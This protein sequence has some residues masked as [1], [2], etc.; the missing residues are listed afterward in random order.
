MTL[1]RTLLFVFF[2]GN[3]IAHAQTTRYEAELA[4]LANGATKVTD[5]SRSGGAYVQTQEGDITFNISIPSDTYFDFYINA[6]A[7][8]G[9]KTNNF[10]IDGSSVSFNM[11]KTTTYSNIKVV[12]F[13][14][15]T[16]GNHTIKIT[17]SWGWINIDYI[18]LTELNPADK[19]NINTSLNHPNPSPE[20]NCLY[21]F[22]RK[23]YN[24][25]IIS[26]VMTLNSFDDAN[27][28]KT[29]IGKEPVVLGIDFLQTNRG[30]SW[31]DDNTPTN[32]AKTWYQKN[33]IPTMMWHWR[34]PSRKTEEFY[35]NK[36]S[37]DASKIND[38]S[39]A[40]YKA[41]ISD[42]DFVAGKLKI[43]K[44][45]G[46]PVI[47]RP[48]HEAAGAWF[49]WGAKGGAVCKKIWQVMYDRMVN[50]HGLNNLIWVW[51]Y[52]PNEDGTWYP[53]DEFVDIIGRD[54]Y[55]DGDHGSQILEFN[56]LNDKYGKKKMI[57]ETE[58]GSFPDVDNLVNDG[59]AWSWFMPWYGKYTEDAT[60]NSVALWQKMFAS[61]Y[62][63]TLDE[64]QPWSSYC[65]SIINKKPAVY[66]TSPANNA[67]FAAP[68]SI[69]ISVTANDTDGT[70]TKVAFYNGSTK[71]GEST[72]APY[73][74]TWTN[75]ASGTDTLTAIATDDNGQT[76]TSAPVI[77]DILQT[78]SIT[79]TS[80]WNLVSFNVHPLDSNIASV[81][82]NLGSD[83]LTVK[84][85]DAF[86]EPSQTSIYNSLVKLE[87]GQAYLIKVKTNKTLTV[88]GKIINTY[89]KSLK[90]GWN[91]VGYPL[92]S[93]SGIATKISGI[94][95]QFE[96][97][98][99][100]DGFYIKNNTTNSLT[101]FVIGKGY[102]LKVNTDCTLNW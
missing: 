24:N 65:A 79:L 55:K 7:P 29:N 37:F 44:N 69:T 48:L 68:A 90:S 75:I 102:F 78:Q 36:T 56:T 87:K 1:K 35:A 83:L 39:S 13:T 51:T 8:N 27:W 52:E 18:E 50:Y 88:T 28:L 82:G 81:F 86:Y 12:S 73:S 9:D 59:A 101:N 46:I 100:F 63:I 97:I 64:M 45:A 70:I 14:K 40:E 47:W 23:N 15:L 33:G 99:N 60:Y 6:S 54:I 17:K 38:A 71:I 84:T 85:A 89:S 16:K 42:I 93:P 32:D 57:A 5:A 98:K 31:Y 34:D 58:C 53:G 91:M 41:M 2:L 62:C 76:N 26:G 77:V 10:V 67:S 92:Q 66:I 96:S 49:W 25:K 20:A 30:Y 21:Q 3:I 95:T 11:T 61:T 80:G 43:L 74:F 4:T 22:L 94:L 72:S 19:F